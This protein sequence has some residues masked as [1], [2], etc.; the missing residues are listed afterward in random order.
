MVFVGGLD[1]CRFS[2]VRVFISF[3]VVLEKVLVLGICRVKSFR[4]MMENGFRDWGNLLFIN[5]F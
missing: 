2:F 5:G 1:F 4:F 3:F